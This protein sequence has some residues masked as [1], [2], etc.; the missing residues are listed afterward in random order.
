MTCISCAKRLM[1]CWGRWNTKFHRRCEKQIKVVGSESGTECSASD[2][3]GTP[4]RVS[5][6]WFNLRVVVCP[7]AERATADCGSLTLTQVNG[8]LPVLQC[9]N[10]Q[11]ARLTG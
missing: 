1:R 3:T 10:R 9:N 7:T 2:A 8:N 6:F 4:T 11:C 5:I